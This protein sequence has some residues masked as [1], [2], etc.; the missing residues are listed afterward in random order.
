MNLKGYFLVFTG[1]GIFFPLINDVFSPIIRQFKRINVRPFEDEQETKDCVEKPLRA[2]GIKP[3]EIFDINTYRDIDSIH[4]LS[5]GRPYEIQLLCHHLFKRMQLGKA[6]DLTLSLD[7]LDDVLNELQSSQDINVRPVVQ[8]IRGLTKD[9]LSALGV[10]LK[11]NKLITFEQA[12]YLE[13]VFNSNTKWTKESLRQY[14]DILISKKIIQIENELLT[15]IG[16]D[17]DRLYCKYYSRK[18]KANVNIND[19]PYLLR[20]KNGVDTRVRLR[21]PCARIYYGNEVFIHEPDME[22]TISNLNNLSID[23]IQSNPELAEILYRENLENQ[24]SPTFPFVLIKM[25]TPWDSFCCWYT[26]KDDTTEPEINKCLNDFEN[27]FSDVKERA[28]E[29]GS[30]LIIRVLYIAVL[31]ADVIT[32][33]FLSVPNQRLKASL[34]LYH[35]SNM[36][37]FYISRKDKE[38]AKYHGSLAYEYLPEPEEISTANNLGY[39]FMSLGEL[40]KAEKLFKIG[41]TRKLDVESRLPYSFESDAEEILFQYLDLVRYNLGIVFAMQNKIAEAKEYITK[42]IEE[43]KLQVDHECSCLFV[44]ELSDNKLGFVGLIEPELRETA[45]KSLEI[46]D[47]YL[48]IINSKDV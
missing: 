44:L 34:S 5:G 30:E 48:N 23:F 15:F 38:M 26:L 6:S 3:E 1:T 29:F 2:L 8:Q 18:F 12:W 35:I 7:V 9:E 36:F 27:V 39:L 37:N 22:K 10:L 46:L 25:S 4:N 33:I 19:M 24:R 45:K 47:Q 20:L 43:S 40:D 11:S 28:S 42:S 21:L 31:P 16:D 14:L 13:Y 41:L 17:F 32:S